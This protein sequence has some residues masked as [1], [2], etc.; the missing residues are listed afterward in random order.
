MDLFN[1]VVN[2]GILT[3]LC[4]CA[5]AGFK[6]WFPVVKFILLHTGETICFCYLFFLKAHVCNIAANLRSFRCHTLALPADCYFFVCSFCFSN[7][8]VKRHHSCFIAPLIH[9]MFLR[10]L[11]V[12]LFRFIWLCEGFGNFTSWLLVT[13]TGVEVAEE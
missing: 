8:E 9:V 2:F 6:H 12:H 7:W 10:S 5:R 4:V 13:A 1:C 3:M 11:F